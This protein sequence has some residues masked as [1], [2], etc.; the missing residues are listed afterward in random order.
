MFAAVS[1]S[2]APLSPVVIVPGDG[3]NILEARLNK[4]SAPHW[5]C[6]K[7]SDWYRLWL[8]TAN[9]LS[10][11]SCW[12]D[13]IRLEVDPTTGR[14]SNAPGVETRV[15]FWGST[16]GLEELDPS[17]PGNPSPNPNPNPN[18]NP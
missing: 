7:T 18:P 16:E 13:N 10:A 15:P 8:N 2:A 3:S 9:L 5:Y 6:S 12:A 14:A 17:I 11:T 1:I 4:P